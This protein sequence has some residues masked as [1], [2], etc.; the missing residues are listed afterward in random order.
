MSAFVGHAWWRTGVPGK[1]K[2]DL[3]WATFTLPKVSALN[4]ARA[5][6]VTS[7]THTSAL[8]AFI[9]Y[10]GR[11]LYFFFF[12]F[13]LMTDVICVAYGGR[14]SAITKQRNY[15]RLSLSRTP[16][17]SMKH[18]EI[19][20]LRHIRFAELRKTINRTN[21]LNRMNM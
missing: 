13:F 8:Q 4:R 18:F 16:R 21:I 2:K 5:A 14:E 17:D 19:S 20:I 10:N 6:A 15:S 7:E 12:F 3:G 9:I 11:R 1:Q